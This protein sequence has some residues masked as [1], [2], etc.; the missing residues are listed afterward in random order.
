LCPLLRVGRCGII[1]LRDGIAWS[2]RAFCWQE[3]VLGWAQGSHE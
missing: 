1:A 2:L 3:V